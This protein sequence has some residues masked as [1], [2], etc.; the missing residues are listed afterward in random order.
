[1]ADSLSITAGVL[2]LIQASVQ[3]TVLLKQFRTDVSVVNATLTGLLSDFDGF[4]QVLESMKETFER[5][6]VRPNLQTTGHVGSH[7]KNLARSLGDGASTLQ[8]LHA[9][10]DS[11]NKTTS[12]LDAPR[13]QLRFK[14]A[15]EQIATYREQIQSYRAALHLS[16]STIIL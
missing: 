16:L 14:S 7:W 1:M 4:Q 13:K 12:I 6:D 8:Q 5:D 9:L 2:A 10:L 3:V 11:I 15:M